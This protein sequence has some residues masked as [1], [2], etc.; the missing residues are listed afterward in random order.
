LKA[1]HEPPG[2]ELLEVHS[3]MWGHV[4]AQPRS[5][6]RRSSC[7]L[8]TR[9]RA[10]SLQATLSVL[11]SGHFHHF[12]RVKPPSKQRPSSLLLGVSAH[13]LETWHSRCLA[14]H[15]G[16]SFSLRRLKQR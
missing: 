11:S 6:Q 2:T 3:Q 13:S 4:F 16:A 5:K 15:V 9:D 7:P 1:V 10:A 12:A 14:A 8:G